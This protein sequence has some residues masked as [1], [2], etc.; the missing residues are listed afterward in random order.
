MYNSGG[1]ENQLCRGPNGREETNAL[2]CSQIHQPSQRKTA[3]A[4]VP[5]SI[6]KQCGAKV[7]QEIQEKHFRAHSQRRGMQK[8]YVT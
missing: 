8:Q 7:E 4:N 6:L 5:E 3:V 2:L 1:C